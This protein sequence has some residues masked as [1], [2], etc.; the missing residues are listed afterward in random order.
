MIEF[1]VRQV[2]AGYALAGGGMGESLF[3]TDFLEV[4]ALK[5]LDHGAAGVN[6]SVR[7]DLAPVFAG[8]AAPGCRETFLPPVSDRLPLRTGPI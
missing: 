8:V 7:L 2:G 3:K 4:K 1:I 6:F 5:I